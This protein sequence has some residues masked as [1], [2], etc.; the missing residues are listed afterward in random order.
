[1]RFQSRSVSSRR[2]SICIIYMTNFSK[3]L[4]V[5]RERTVTAVKTNSEDE[6]P[7]SSSILHNEKV[8]GSRSSSSCDGSFWLEY[9]A[10]SGHHSAALKCCVCQCLKC[11][12]FLFAPCRSYF[13]L[14]ALLAIA[15]LNKDKKGFRTWV[16]IASFEKAHARTR[17][18][19]SQRSEPPTGVFL[20]QSLSRTLAEL[21]GKLMCR[22]N[23]RTY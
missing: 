13:R 18:G 8:L 1:M 3:S 10:G 16:V 4:V 23:Q 11:V 2:L 12:I 19:E 9:C 15:S 5:L 6:F 7:V 14:N 22:E 20:Y 17:W 21:W